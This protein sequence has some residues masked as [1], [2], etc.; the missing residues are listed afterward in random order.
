MILNNENYYSP[1]ANQEYMSVS[2]YKQKQAV[3]GLLISISM[4]MVA[5]LPARAFPK[6]ISCRYLWK[7][8]E[9]YL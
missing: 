8:C 7:R 5:L 6:M 9:M 1:E 2:Q 4:E 3:T